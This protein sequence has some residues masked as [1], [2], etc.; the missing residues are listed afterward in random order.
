MKNNK[1]IIFLIFLLTII[2]IVLIIFMFSMIN[3]KTK[4]PIFNFNNKVSNKLVFEQTYE[5]MFDEIII[6]S[7]SSNIYIKTS[8][9]NLVKVVI[10][11]DEDKTNV[12]ELDNKLTI[13]LKE[14]NCIGFCFNYTVPKIEVYLPKDYKN[15]INITNNYGDVEIDE[16]LNANMEILEDCGDVKIKGGNTIK[17]TNDYGDIKISN[18]NDIDIKESAGDVIIGSV[19]NVKVENDYGDIEIDK[20]NNY[21]DLNNNCGDIKLENINL[22]KNSSITDSYGDI[23]IGKTNEIYIDAKTDLGDIKINNNY[24]KSD[25]NLKIQNDC[26]DIKINN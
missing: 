15:N 2:S 8:E 5:K 10:Y 26:G 9:D 13:T 1:F 21:L 22:S 16:F 18:A 19:N 14:K 25:I 23:K 17:V 6:N 7:S 4:F 11:S 12:T 20:V 3:G 24:N